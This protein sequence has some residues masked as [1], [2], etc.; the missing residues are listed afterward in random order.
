M[1]ITSKQILI[2]REWLENA[3]LCGEILGA[4]TPEFEFDEFRHTLS[5]AL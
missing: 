5:F 1:K 4:L 2:S 3:G